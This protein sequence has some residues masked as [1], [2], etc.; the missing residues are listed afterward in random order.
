MIFRNHRINPGFIVVGSFVFTS[1]VHYFI[2]SRLQQVNSTVHAFIGTLLFF[3]VF[4]VSSS[5]NRK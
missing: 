3:I 1:L 2:F 5:L 4:T